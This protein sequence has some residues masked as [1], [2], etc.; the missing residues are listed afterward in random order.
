MRVAQP[1]I[2]RICA[3]SNVSY[4]LTS[5]N[6][7]LECEIGGPETTRVQMSTNFYENYS[8]AEMNASRIVT[9]AQIGTRDPEIT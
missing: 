5:N 3:I 2:I 1:L 4:L 7:E 9:V 8:L 6:V